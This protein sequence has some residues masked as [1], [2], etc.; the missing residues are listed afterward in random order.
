MQD[1]GTLGG[2][3][4]Y[5]YGINNSGQVTGYSLTPSGAFHAFV[6]SAATGMQDIGTLGGTNSYGY[7]INDSGQV[8]GYSL[9]PSGPFHAFIATRH[10]VPSSPTEVKATAANAEAIVTFT[11]PASNGGSAI[12]G[13]TVTSSPG[14][15]E[16]KGNASPIPVKGLTNGKAYTFTVTATNKSGTGP[17]SGPSNPVTPATVPGAPTQ[18]TAK[19]GDTQATVSFKLPA[20]G[21]SPITGCTVTSNPGGIK[22]KGVGSPITVKGLT[23]GIAYT[24]RVTATNKIG[25]GPASSAS[26]PVKPEAL[27][28]GQK[29][30]VA[31]R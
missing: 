11:P 22:G 31:H 12:T 9:T 16:A 1:I 20:N 3:N 8:T 27:Q 19:A 13:Y 7:G 18:V 30:I 2:T 26:S 24:F 23:N 28:R 5:G 29:P 10:G 6:Y 4:S 14:S 21:G 17:P 25:T 15:I